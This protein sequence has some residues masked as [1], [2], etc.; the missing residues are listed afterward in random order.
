MQILSLNIILIILSH[1]KSKLRLREYCTE[2]RIFHIHKYEQEPTIIH[3]V[4]VSISIISNS[5]NMSIGKQQ[6]T[7]NTREQSVEKFDIH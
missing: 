1:D 3:C 2:S 7:I 6:I 5:C 4:I